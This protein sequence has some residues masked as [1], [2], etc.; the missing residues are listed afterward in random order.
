MT[1]HT[2]NGVPI[3]KCTQDALYAEYMAGLCLEAQSGLS[4]AQMARL[5]AIEALLVDSHEIAGT[6]PEPP[7]RS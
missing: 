5:S 1:D 3:A 2:L 7:P 6:P 4:D